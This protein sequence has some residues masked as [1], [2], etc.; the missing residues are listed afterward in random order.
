M[1]S[2]HSVRIERELA[3]N[4]LTVLITQFRNIFVDFVIGLEES[5]FRHSDLTKTDLK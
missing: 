4:K 5:H 2:T 1:S 3:V